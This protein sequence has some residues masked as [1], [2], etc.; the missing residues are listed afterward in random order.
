[1][2]DTRAEDKT[3]Q[4]AIVSSSSE[5]APKQSAMSSPRDDKEF[6]RPMDEEEVDYEEDDLSEEGEVPPHHDDEEKDNKVHGTSKNTTIVTNSSDREEE[7]A[8]LKYEV[9][10]TPQ[11]YPW[12]LSTWVYNR[13]KGYKSDLYP[14]PLFQCD[15]LLSHGDFANDKE[16]DAYLIDLFLQFRFFEGK[17]KKE[18]SQEAMAQAWN[19]FVEN[20]NKGPSAW[21]ARLNKAKERHRERTVTGRAMEIH[22]LSRGC[23]VPCAVQAPVKCPMCM[24]AA[25]HLARDELNLTSKWSP[26]VTKELQ[27]AVEQLDNFIERENEH[28][29]R[30]RVRPADASAMSARPRSRPR[31][32]ERQVPETPSTPRYLERE[33]TLSNEPD[34]GVGTSH[35]L[36]DRDDQRSQSQSSVCDPSNP[37]KVAVEV[38]IP[39]AEFHALQEALK[40][41]TEQL[42][43]QSKTISQLQCGHMELTS[44]HLRLSGQ[45]QQLAVDTTRLDGQLQ[46]LNADHQRLDR[47]HHRMADVLVRKNVI[48]DPKRPR[49]SDTDEDDQHKT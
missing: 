13:F 46:Q 1:M 7:L 44:A 47:H 15:N 19:A 33:D 2:S 8:A 14:I 24:P 12:K 3:V 43:S 27:L 36:V 48:K 38:G 17:M 32:L 26:L 5:E 20:F 37:P 25:Q 30:S 18:A 45:C 6:P 23:G 21:L 9:S 28:G 49:A 29:S 22:R 39:P 41:A 31:H 34:T 42:A 11:R 40:R 16:R 4:T 35:E 10:R